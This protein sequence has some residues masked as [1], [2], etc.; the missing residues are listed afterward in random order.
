MIMAP[1]LGGDARSPGAPT[2]IVGDVD[3]RCRESGSAH[4][5][6]QRRQWCTPW[7]AMSRVQE[8]PPP[9]LDTSI[10]D[11]GS[12]EA[13]TTIVRDVDDGP[14]PP[15]LGGSGIHPRSESVL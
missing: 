3:R 1:P 6:C 15:P 7:E 10:G 13:P 2:T 12:P 11:A 5:H 14:L 4:Y 9:L 8:R